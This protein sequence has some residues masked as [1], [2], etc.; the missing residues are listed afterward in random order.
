MP[1]MDIEEV[2]VMFKKYIHFI[3]GSSWSLILLFMV[4]AGSGL[5][6]FTKLPI[7]ALP[8]I[9]PVMVPI[10]TEAHGMAPQEIEQYITYP[11][12]VRMQGLPGVTHTKSTSAQG[13][14]VV[15]IYF[16]DD[17]DIYFSRQ[18]VAERLN[19]IEAE[20]PP[21][22]EPPKLGPIS[23]GLGQI[24]IYYLTFEADEAKKV[25]N[26]QVYLREINDRIIKPRLRVIQGVTDVLSM[27]GE[28][29][30]IQIDLD[31][32]KMMKYGISINKVKNEIGD[33]NFNRSGQYIVFGDEEYSVRGIGIYQSIKQLENKIIDVR[34]GRAILLRHIA[35]VKEG[36][37]L[38]RG[39][40]SRNGEKEIV[41]GIVLQLYGE[42]PATVIERLK[43]KVPEI[44]KSLPHG[45]KIVSYYDQATIIHEAVS[46]ITHALWQGGALV[47][48]VILLFLNSWRSATIIVSALPLCTLIT[49]ALMK[50]LGI[51][52]NLMSLGGMAIALGMLVDGTIVV[53]ENIHRHIKIDPQRNMNTAIQFA[54][55]EV[56]RAIFSVCSSLF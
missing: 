32:E 45:V 6:L 56:S 15:Y 22:A 31:P 11:I 21:L 9:S 36:T 41:S 8:D 34:N 4:C 47:I 2:D 14:S 48:L 42:N 16:S 29:Q 23:T 38:R 52:A 55:H 1:A 26:P 7:E 5:Y 17:R 39:V 10:F 24:F 13:L 35:N 51:S 44:Q 33:Q 49:F 12:E 20:L 19:S 28:I 54:T 50:L 30:Q 25:Q 3:L 40:V 18:L 53:I 43:N 37:A 27:G 46:T